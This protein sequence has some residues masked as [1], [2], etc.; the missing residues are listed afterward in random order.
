MEIS[1]SIM[2]QLNTVLVNKII[3]I[4]KLILMEMQLEKM[5][6]CLTLM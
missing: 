4:L 2:N 1:I 3:I 6:L 5:K